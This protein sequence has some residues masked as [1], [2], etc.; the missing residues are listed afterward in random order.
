MNWMQ[1]TAT[2]MDTVEKQTGKP[3][4]VE[5]DPKLPT[6]ARV[7]MAHGGDSAHRIIHRPAAPNLDY[8]VAFQCGFIIRLYETPPSDRF[9]FGE[10]ETGR[11]SARHLVSEAGSAL[12]RKGIPMAMLSQL[13]GQFFDGL[14]TQLRS[15]PIGM[16]VE[17][18]LW[19][20]FPELHDQHKDCVGRQ[21][22]ENAQALGPQI[23]G[24]TP[25]PIY[26]SNAAMNCAYAMFADRLFGTPLYEVPYRSAGFVERGSRLLDLFDGMATEASA[27]RQLVDAWGQDL[28]LSD[29][30][31]WVPFGAA[32]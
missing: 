7:S 10:S 17:S 6:M 19:E 27:D 29:W 20:C 31:T 13:A 26:N 15:I 12:Q 32:R 22:R 16:R 14:L 4:H 2:I 9:E 8:L 5:V 23:R 25:G 24:M 3:I 1:A 21:Q 11:A 28:G 18:W 30:Y